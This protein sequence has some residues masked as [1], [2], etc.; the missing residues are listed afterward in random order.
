MADDLWSTTEVAEY[1]GIG[2]DSV[3]MWLHRAEVKAVSRQAGN[4]GENLY[5]VADITGIRQHEG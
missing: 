1:L 3:Y 2:R 5:R 4:R